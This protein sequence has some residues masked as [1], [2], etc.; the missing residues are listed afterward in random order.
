MS[1]NPET[2]GKNTPDKDSPAINIP[3]MLIN[4]TII[5]LVFLGAGVFIGISLS[6]P[7]PADDAIASAGLSEEQVRT[8]MMDVLAEADLGSSA[9]ERFELVD[10]DPYLGDEEAP[11]VIVEF[12]DFRCPYCGRHF[13]QT[14]GPLLENYGEHIRYVYRD[15]P[16]NGPESNAA[17]IAAECA[18]EQGE[19]WDFHEA[20]FDNQAD[21]GRDFYIS[22]AESFDLDVDEF[23]TCI[24]EVRY[25]DELELDFIDGQM[26]GVSGTPGFFINGQFIRGAQPYLVFER[27]VLRELEKAG[28]D[29]DEEATQS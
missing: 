20:L 29:P 22:T 9:S 25:Q 10:D 3:G 5:A 6:T 12:S 1:D 16:V 26:N 19:F 13:E 21:L 2:P 15:F 11:V 17:A 14:L 8:I 24:D 18:D 4:Y 27:A 23:T 28:I 7:A